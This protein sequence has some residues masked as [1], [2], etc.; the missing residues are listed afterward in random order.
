MADKP[1]VLAVDDESDVLLLLKTALSEDYDVSTASSGPEA[2]EKAAA[3]P[4]DVIILDMM[5]PGM[6]GLEVLDRLRKVPGT[7][8]TPVLF[9][10]GVS[11]RAKIRQALDMGTAYYLT[12][13]FSNFDL[14]SKVSLALKEAAG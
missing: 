4:P 14:L 2:L 1:T 6:D 3:A 8:S 12:K 9:L 11:D 7:A 13:P 5:M 10:T